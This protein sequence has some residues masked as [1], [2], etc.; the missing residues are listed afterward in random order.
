M[1]ARRRAANK[2]KKM[3]LTGKSKST[4]TDED[5]EEPEEGS[6]MATVFENYQKSLD[7]PE[8]GFLSDFQTSWMATLKSA[9]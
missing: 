2:R 8:R 1:E 4:E 6:I 7:L 9:F 3:K 5:D